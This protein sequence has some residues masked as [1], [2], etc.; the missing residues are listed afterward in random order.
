MPMPNLHILE[1]GVGKHL[2]FTALFD[3]LVEKNNEKL[4]LMTPWPELFQHDPRVSST[5]SL[6]LAPLHDTSHTLF[7]NYNNIIYKDPY[8]S[9]FLKGD[10]HL[11]EFWS[12]M[13]DVKEKE[14]LPNFYINSKREKIIK[15]DILKLGKFILIQF[16]GGQGLIQNNYDEINAGRNYKEGQE[17]INLLKESLPEINIIVFSHPNEQE[18]LL[19]TTQTMFT[20]KLDFMIL[21]KYCLSFIC[22]DSSLQH[23]CSNKSFNKK[24]VVLWGTSHSSMFGYE[25]NVNLI[26]DYPYVV[27][28]KPQKIVDCFLQQEIS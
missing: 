2:Q 17:V 6:N 9:N 11:I 13:Y 20:D 27:E 4:C 18:P 25:K 15:P 19:N 22:I 8:K 12:K 14:L 16:T 7:K 5:H 10:T 1:G 21:A 3:K 23:I 28:I 26:S 24:G